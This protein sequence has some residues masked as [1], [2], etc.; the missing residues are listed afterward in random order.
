M[1]Y[2]P[3]LCL[4][5]CAN[6]VEQP[7]EGG[8][9]VCLRLGIA[10][11]PIGMEDGQHDSHQILLE[12]RVVRVGPEMPLADSGAEDLLDGLGEVGVIADHLIPH[13]AGLIVELH[14]GRGE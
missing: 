9:G 7:L 6:G 13:H 4:T 1:S 14:A 5:R 3:S 11:Q 12:L 8:S 2:V 10:E